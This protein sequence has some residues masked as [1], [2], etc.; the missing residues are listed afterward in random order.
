MCSR[1]APRLP[2]AAAAVVLVLLGLAAPP[3]S[4]A[5]SPIVAGYPYANRCPAAG[6]A[7]KVD[8]WKMYVCNC[9]SY[10]A[11]ALSANGQRIDWFVPGVMDAKNWARVALRA[12]IGV[13]HTPRIGSVAVWPRESKFGHVAYVTHVD[14]D[15]NF[16]VSEYNLPGDEA[17]RFTFDVRREVSSA[18]A[19][20]VYVPKR[21]EPRRLL[22]A[23][24]SRAHS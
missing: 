11:W 10:A 9:T 14:P 17:K 18:G 22:N 2:I 5:A 15:G 7:E 6:V 24:G 3:A 13:G 21:A 19:V 1:G 16:D 4:R 20:F 8:R 23:R 12:G